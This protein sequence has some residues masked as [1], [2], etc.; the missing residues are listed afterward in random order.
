MLKRL[1]AILVASA[2][3][4][5]GGCNTSSTGGSPG[6][7][8][9]FKIAGPDLATTLKQGEKKVVKITVTRKND[10][11]DALAF[12]ATEPN[13]L[14]VTMDHKTLASSDPA[15]VNLTVEA[16]KNAPLGEH[17]IKVTAKPPSGKD[18]FV[19]VKVKVEEGPKS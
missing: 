18:V 4:A 7:D 1:S 15:E 13:G 6:T 19:D 3:L 2:A 16:E 14:K 10:F 11:K 9:A 8:Y 5:F 17:I 12:S